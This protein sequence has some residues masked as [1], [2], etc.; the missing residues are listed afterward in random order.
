MEQDTIYSSSENELEDY[1]EFDINEIINDL[2]NQI[3]M[4]D[5]MI[6]ILWNNVMVK[7]IENGNL[8][9]KLSSND[10]DKFYKYMLKNSKVIN[11]L[12]NSYNKMQIKLSKKCT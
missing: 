3:N 9:D 8:L 4:F 1:N 12:Y 7:Y 6:D 10:K 2:E 11:D 5:E